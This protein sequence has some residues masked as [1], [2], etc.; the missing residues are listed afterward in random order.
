[1]KE[2]CS[3][4]LPSVT[5][6]GTLAESRHRFIG[7]SGL[8]LTVTDL[9]LTTFAAGQTGTDTPLGLG[10]H[11]LVHVF[12]LQSLILGT[13]F[14]TLQLFMRHANESIGLDDTREHLT[15]ELWIAL[16]LEILVE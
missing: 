10:D 13:L 3:R 2:G 5:A 14:V 7:G 12:L 11:G 4:E 8:G 1:M 9:L 16:V 6:D 15:T